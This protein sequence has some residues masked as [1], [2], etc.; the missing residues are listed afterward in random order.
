MGPGPRVA[1]RF[2]LA[3]VMGALGAL[4]G[5]TACGGGARDTT[6][7]DALPGTLGG[8]TANAALIGARE[9]AEATAWARLYAGLPQDDASP[10]RALDSLAPVRKHQ[11]VMEQRWQ[12]FD[13]DRFDPMRKWASRE[14]PRP[15]GRTVF[16]PF[17]GPDAATPLALFPTGT[18]YVLV[19]LEPPGRLAMPGGDSATVA[20]LPTVAKAMRSVMSLGFFL[21]NEM[22]V[23]LDSIGV[24]PVLAAMAV[25]SGFTVIGWRPVEIDSAGSVVTGHDEDALRPASKR[26]AAGVELTLRTGDGRAVLMQYFA[27]DLGDYA[28]QSMPRAER[29]FGGM[30]QVLT[31]TKATSYLLHKPYF[32]KLRRMILTQSDEIVQDDSGVPWRF[33]ST[34]GWSPTLYGKYVEPISMFSEWKQAELETVTRRGPRRPLP[35]AFG[36]RHQKS[37]A[38]L[39]VASKGSSN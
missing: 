31:V 30:T 1:R 33:L 15:P 26:Q 10:K 22:A 4:S 34:N 23:D 7:R 21:T 32:S 39:I 14:L 18:R 25:R 6:A 29:A 11:K 36:Y 19:G 20:Q 16:Y 37:Q 9:Q 8:D 2:V 35:F 38:G 5:L 3:A 17:A 13:R 28:L 27:V 24:A 12:L